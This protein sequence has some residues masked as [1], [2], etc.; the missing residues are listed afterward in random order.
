MGTSGGRRERS[1]MRGG[2]IR[3]DNGEVKLEA[4]RLLSLLKYTKGYGRRYALMFFFLI[5]QMGTYQLLAYSL[6]YLIN[7]LIPAK[8]LDWLLMFLGG[9][10]VAFAVHGV[11][12]L[13]AARQRIEIVQTLVA[14]IRAK[15]IRKM[16]VLCIKYFDTRGTGASSARL[17]M[18][19]DKTQ[20]FY[21]WMMVNFLQGVIGIVMVIPLLSTIDL[22]LTIVSAIYVP[23]IPFI[24]RLFR[25]FLMTRAHRL[26]D[27]NARL[28]EKLVDFI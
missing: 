14:R 16:Q 13:L 7:D 21:R 10:I 3:G 9:W 1:M 8:R 15:L 19:V 6:K 18:D 20:Q 23:S 4:R 27:T 28:S 5:F 17:L 12:T 11:F 24:Q 2:D 26:R 25:K 22:R